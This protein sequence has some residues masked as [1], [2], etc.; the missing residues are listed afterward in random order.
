[1]K[2]IFTILALL[3]LMS[4]SSSINVN[5]QITLQYSVDTITF[6]HFYC[7]DLGNNDFKYVILDPVSN[8]FHLY[9]MDMTPFMSVQIP[10][11][12]SIKNGYTVIYITKTLFDCDSSNVEYVYECANCS[13]FRKPFYIFRTNGDL[14]FKADSTVAPYDFGTYGGSHDTRPIFNTSDGAKLLLEKRLQIGY[15]LRIY[16]LCGSL[17]TNIYDFSVHR[18]YVK[19]YPNPTSM[20]LNFEITPPNNQDEFQLVIFD[21]NSKEQKRKSI[22]LINN[23]YSLD[24][25]NLGNGTYFFSLLSKS[26]VY[27]TGKFMI[28]K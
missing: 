5:A 13:M 6:D 16:S 23:K 9:N 20:E 22:A 25:S 8:G 17:P 12:D 1:M 2:K 21:S 3:T 14:L 4:A 18:Q 24:V 26:K 7:T 19:I 11:N 28:T 27:Q 10:V 15:R